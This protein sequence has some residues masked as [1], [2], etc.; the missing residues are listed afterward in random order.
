M[1]TK[2]I[3]FENQLRLFNQSP[4]DTDI[5]KY[6]TTKHQ[7]TPI[8]NHSGKNLMDEFNRFDKEELNKMLYDYYMNDIDSDSYEFSNLVYNNQEIFIDYIKENPN[9]IASQYKNLWPK[10]TDIVNK[11]LEEIEDNR[12]WYETIDDYI[13]NTDTFKTYLL[14][15]LKDDLFDLCDQD[16]YYELETA[17]YNSEDP[18]RLRVFRSISLPENVTELDKYKGVGVYWTYEFDKA[19]AYNSRYEREYILDGWVYADAI[20]W[21]QTI[22]RSLYNLKEEREIKLYDGSSIQLVEV[23]METSYDELMDNIEER[24]KISK[25]FG[26]SLNDVMKHLKGKYRNMTKIVLDNFW[27]RVGNSFQ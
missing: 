26:L 21:E 27:V 12:Q 17:I 3:L 7:T 18:K 15:K 9:N 22:Y 13:V 4:N 10:G 11:I 1:I 14:E 6:F 8:T 20:D 19:E 25:L 2:F 23:F 24:E 16:Y 5:S